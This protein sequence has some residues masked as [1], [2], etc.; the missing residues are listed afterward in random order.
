MFHALEVDVYC[1][2]N[3]SEEIASTEFMQEAYQCLLYSL[4]Q[5]WEH[6]RGKL[7]I[8]HN[9]NYLADALSERETR[10]MR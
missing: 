7:V 4:H 2:K 6:E 9:R 10:H 5:K 3:S 1:M 8:D